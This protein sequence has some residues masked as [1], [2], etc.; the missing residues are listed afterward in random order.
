VGNGTLSAAEHFSLA[1]VDAGRVTV[2][3]QRSAGTDGN[4]TGV[5]LPGAFAMSFTGMEI[6][7]ADAPKSVFHG[8][9]IQPDIEVP[10]TAAAFRDGIDPELQVAVSFLLSLP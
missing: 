5:Q 8:I 10:F 4:I 6:R 1:L 9:G 3:G 2:I 7:H